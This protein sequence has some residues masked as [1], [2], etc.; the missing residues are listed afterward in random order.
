MWALRFMLL[1]MTVTDDLPVAKQHLRYLKRFMKSLSEEERRLCSRKVP[2]A[3]LLTLDM[4]PWR[5][6]LASEVDQALITMTG[7]DGVSFKSLLQKFAPLFNDY[8][9]FNTSHILL[10]QD[11]SKGG[12]PRKV[13]PEDCLG[14]VLVWTRTR[15]SLTALQLIF[16]LSCSNLCMYLRFG[17]RVIVE[18][19]KIDSLAMIAIPSNEIIALYQEA[20][21]AIYPLLSDVWSTMDGLKLYL[22]Q[23]GNTEIQACYYNGWTHGHYVT[24]IF[25]FCPD[26]TIPIAFFNVPGSVHDSQ[27]AHWGRVYDELGAV[28]DDT[29]GKCTVDSAFSKVNRPFLIKSSQDYLMSTMP[30]C[31]E[32]RED[33]QRK[34]QA[35]SMR[36]AAEW[37]MRAIQSSFPRLKDTFVYEDTGERRILMKMVCLLY[38]LRA[39]T[40]GINQIKNV[41]IRH[42]DANANNDM[43]MM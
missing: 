32:Q 30:T 19:L 23:L 3:S 22:Q 12:R 31:H 26:G 13:R 39:R 4:S 37:G 16:G 24:S 14:L 5:T 38:N 42:L 2:C 15:G 18:A 35:T 36:Q 17:C 29:G 33:I 41:F 7:F 1:Q 34:G 20:V 25:V 21:G 8:T 28:Y 11:P 27:V 10:K 6:L 43:N 9:P 40:V